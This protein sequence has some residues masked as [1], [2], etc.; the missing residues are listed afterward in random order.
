[1]SDPSY[2]DGPIRLRR[3]I[4]TLIALPLIGGIAGAVLRHFVMLE[5]LS[6]RDGR[7]A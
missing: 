3:L 6:V 4:S 1:V 5:T 2:Y 7:A